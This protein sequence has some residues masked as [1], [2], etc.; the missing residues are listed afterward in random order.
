MQDKRAMGEKKR[1]LGWL[2][3]IVYVVC[4]VD[5]VYVAC[6][7]GLLASLG[8]ASTASAFAESPALEHV[9]LAY[10]DPGSGSF[11]VQALIA[12]FAGIAVTLRLYWARLMSLLGMG[13]S[14][15]DDDFDDVSASGDIG[16]QDAQL[17]DA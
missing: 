10:L 8:F 15:G 5:V 13:S 1:D 11:V 17:D 12:M 16:Q 3:G 7:V 9:R 6:G 2:V 4:V 14:E